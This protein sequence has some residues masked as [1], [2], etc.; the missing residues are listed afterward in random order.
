MNKEKAIRKLQKQKAE[1]LEKWVDYSGVAEAFDMAI[2]ALE[3]SKRKKGKWIEVNSD[4]MPT[5]RC[6]ECGAEFN[7]WENPSEFG[8]NFC[9]NCGADMRGET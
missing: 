2:E 5:Y 3:Q 4:M 1:Y 6:S 7:Y 9:Q 8:V